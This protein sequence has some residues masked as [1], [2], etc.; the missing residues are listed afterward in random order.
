MNIDPGLG[1]IGVSIF[2][3]RTRTGIIENIEIETFSSE[4]IRDHRGIDPL[5][6]G[7][8]YLKLKKIY[9]RIN[10]LCHH[11]RPAIVFHESPFYNR[12]RPNAYEVLVEALLEIRSAIFDYNR[13]TYIERIAPQAVKKGIGAGGTKGKEIIMEKVFEIP[14]LMDVLNYPKEE[15]T[16]HCIDSMAIGYTGLRTILGPQENWM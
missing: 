8:R 7:E 2:D 10:D 15:L 5:H 3:V 11:Y 4:G 14:A 16:E 6:T 1:M 13:D 12:F 9:N